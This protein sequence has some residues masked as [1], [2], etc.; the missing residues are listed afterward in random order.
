MCLNLHIAHAAFISCTV[1]AAIA[2]TAHAAPAEEKTPKGPSLAAPE[3]ARIHFSCR[4]EPPEAR[5]WG[6]GARLGVCRWR[7]RLSAAAE[8]LSSDKN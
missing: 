5:G 3:C 7:G 8:A 4:N 1:T 6:D 2:A